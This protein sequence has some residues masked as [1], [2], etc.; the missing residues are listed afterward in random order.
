MM[1]TKWYLFRIEARQPTIIS[2]A[3]P[4]KSQAEKERDKFPER[5]RKAIGVG[6]VKS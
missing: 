2:K 5:D 4:T 6:N 3:F 1:K